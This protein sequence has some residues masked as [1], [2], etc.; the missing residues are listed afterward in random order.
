[1]PNKKLS[2]YGDMN[3]ADNLFTMS[4]VEGK[5]LTILGFNKGPGKFGEIYYIKAAFDTGEKV[6]VMCGGFLVKDALDEAQKAEAFPLEATFVKKGR[7]WIA[8]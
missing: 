8:E 1:M 3:S 5:P 2:Q 4:D 6:T 7:A